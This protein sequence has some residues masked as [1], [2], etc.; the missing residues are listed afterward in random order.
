MTAHRQPQEA[1]SL[2]YGE[3]A[4]RRMCTLALHASAH[5]CKLRAIANQRCQ[6]V[7]IRFVNRKSHLGRLEYLSQA[8]SSHICTANRITSIES[9]ALIAMVMTVSNM[10]IHSALFCGD[11]Q[12]GANQSQT[13]WLTKS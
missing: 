1:I 3:C 8:L 12:T 4:R 11:A 10:A 13:I 9:V 5:L 6:R 7:H 2:P